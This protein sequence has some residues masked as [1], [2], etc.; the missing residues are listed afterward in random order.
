MSLNVWA[1]QSGSGA[2]LEPPA[3]VHEEEW[4]AC[5]LL[6]HRLMQQ[7]WLLLQGRLLTTL[8]RLRR[9]RGLGRRLPGLLGPPPPARHARLD[10]RHLLLHCEERQ[11]CAT[12][13]AA[14]LRGCWAVGRRRC[15]P[16]TL[17]ARLGSL[18]LPLLL[19][20]LL[21]WLL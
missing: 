9:G 8:L 14:L 16:C 13:P 12:H 19:S 6:L 5:G 3:H 1:S 4:I 20:L 15:R 21:R 17:L 18:P 2:H 11:A 10:M 7:C